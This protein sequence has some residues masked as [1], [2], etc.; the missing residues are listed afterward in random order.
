MNLNNDQ[1]LY[2]KTN[3]YVRL[4]G[5]LDI[6]YLKEIRLEAKACFTRQLTRIGYSLNKSSTEKDFEQWLYRLFNEDYDAFLGAAKL[7]QHTVS[8]FRLSTNHGLI[9]ILKEVG[10]KQPVICVKPIM[11]FNSRHI[12]KIEG[13]YKTPAHQDWRSMQGSLNSAV[14]WIPLVNINRNLG[15]L[16]V[17]P[18]SHRRGLLPTEKDEWFRHI[19]PD[20]IN[21][22]DFLSLDVKAGDIVIFNSFLV[23]RSGNNDTDSIRWS[24]HCRYNDASEETWIKRKFIHPYKV[25]HHNK[26]ISDE[27]FPSVD[28][29]NKIL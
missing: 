17:I 18:K 3:C 1:L 20:C 5:F 24:L 14:I 7:C 6:D 27:N 9:N 19:H 29:R 4:K 11:Y 8:L 26:E 2:Y 12:S 28:Q 23:H 22:D 16:E 13:H 21:N 10:I 25:Y 15:A